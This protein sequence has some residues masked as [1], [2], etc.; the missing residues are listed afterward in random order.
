MTPL[1]GDFFCF[2]DLPAELRLLIY[3]RIQTSN[4]HINL[5]KLPSTTAEAANSTW[6]VALTTKHPQSTL[7]HTCRQ[8]RR[9]YEP[10]FLRAN[11]D[12]RSQPARFLVHH[13]SL[14]NFTVLGGLAGCIDNKFRP[15][16]SAPVLPASSYETLQMMTTEPRP[17]YADFKSFIAKC[18]LYMRSRRIPKVVVA[19][20]WTS[21]ALEL[22]VA[23]LIIDL[24]DLFTSKPF[25]RYHSGP[26]SVV[27]CQGLSEAVEG[28]D[29]FTPYN[30]S[31][32]QASDRQIDYQ[33]RTIT[34]QIVVLGGLMR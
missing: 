13:L 18:V 11:E 10:I 17:A 24:Q 5:A 12:L 20:R 8:I 29:M 16:A 22:D 19:V 30:Q 21:S 32:Q 27:I 14:H 15:S 33:I 4:R 23:G 25:Q 7:L 9:E 6:E 2:L 1:T 34:D 3:E 28:S 31:A 26:I